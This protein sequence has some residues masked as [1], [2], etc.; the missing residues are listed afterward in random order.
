[1]RTTMVNAKNQTP[2]VLLPLFTVASDEAH[3]SNVKKYETKKHC[4]TDDGG[5]E[6]VTD[7]K[8]S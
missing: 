8:P 6:K 7:G 3:A 4:M 5:G 1:M 2:N